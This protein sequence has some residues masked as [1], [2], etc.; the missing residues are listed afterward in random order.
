MLLL[1]ISLIT[2]L[3]HAAADANTEI[4]VTEAPASPPAVAYTRHPM[5]PV[6]CER[7]TKALCYGIAADITAET[8]GVCGWSPSEGQCAVV[9]IGEEP[10]EASMCYLHRTLADC[11]SS[12]VDPATQMGLPMPPGAFDAIERVC[13]WNPYSATCKDGQ[14]ENEPGDFVF[15]RGTGRGCAW[16]NP[17][18]LSCPRPFCMWTGAACVGSG[19]NMWNFDVMPLASTHE[20]KPEKS[21]DT[22]AIAG[23]AV[24]GFGIGLAMACG[25]VNLRSRKSYLTE[26]LSMERVV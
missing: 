12:N 2:I 4:T 17:N 10:K 13:A 20:S 23:F 3:T 14:L 7:Q 26:P 8:D 15:G 16:G 1:S 9:S 19:R 6:F 18:A 5:T 25:Y 22:F 21:S 11:I 24:G